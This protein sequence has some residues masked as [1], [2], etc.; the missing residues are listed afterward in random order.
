[1]YSESMT[2]ACLTQLLQ[3]PCDLPASFLPLPIHLVTEHLADLPP[4][5]FQPLID[6][7]L[8]LCSITDTTEEVRLSVC[9]LLLRMEL[10]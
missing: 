7:L 8:T 10:Q 6:S 5:S 4:T 9:N 2:N 1:M 3:S